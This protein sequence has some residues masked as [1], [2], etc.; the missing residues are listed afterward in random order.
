MSPTTTNEKGRDSGKSATQTTS[1]DHTVGRRWHVRQ[2]AALS[3]AG[4]ESLKA[5]LTAHAKTPAEYERACRQAA[6]LAGV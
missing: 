4:Y 6:R 3:Y 5:A 1:N 2:Y